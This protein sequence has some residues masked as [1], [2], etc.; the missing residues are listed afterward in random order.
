M[1]GFFDS[2]KSDAQT[3]FDTTNTA[4][5]SE[6]TKTVSWFFGFSFTFVLDHMRDPRYLAANQSRIDANTRSAGALMRESDGLAM[7]QRNWA[8][9][10]L[11]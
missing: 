10:S 6:Y 11:R 7:T 8:P 5:I 1:V 9:P 4:L 2:L 3:R